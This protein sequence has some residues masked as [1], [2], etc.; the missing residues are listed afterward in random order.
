MKFS[1]KAIFYS[2][3]KYGDLTLNLRQR[4]DGIGIFAFSSFLLFWKEFLQRNVVCYEL[5]KYRKV[6]FSHILLKSLEKELYK[7]S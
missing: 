7:Q 6:F 3:I 2:K 5:N 1:V 4:D